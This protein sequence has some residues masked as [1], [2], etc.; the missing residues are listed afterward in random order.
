MRKFIHVLPLISFLILSG[1]SSIQTEINVDEVMINTEL[2][3]AKSIVSMQESVSS[4]EETEIIEGVNTVLSTV[5]SLQSMI[6]NSPDEIQKINEFGMKLDDD[7]DMIEK[8]VE[9]QFPKDYKIIEE[10]LYPLIDEAKSVKPEIDQLK[11]LID[12]VN[13]KLVKFKDKISS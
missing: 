7:W 13:G 1:F 4:S 10:S 2:I 12:E 6:A 9:E 8:R 5:N 3:S 11:K